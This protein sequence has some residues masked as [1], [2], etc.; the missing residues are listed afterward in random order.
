MRNI[1]N[2]CSFY[3]NTHRAGQQGPS[4]KHS[5][6]MR[7]IYV[8]RGEERLTRANGQWQE[9]ICIKTLNWR[10]CKFHEGGSM[11]FQNELGISFMPIKN[12]DIILHIIQNKKIYL[13]CAWKFSHMNYK[14]QI[15]RVILSVWEC[16]E[17]TQCLIG[18]TAE[19]N[20]S[21]K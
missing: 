15:T 14:A 7:G 8:T 11:R 9:S 10:K 13:S 20:G 21:S 17:M 5:R 3:L 6:E 12:V 19:L 4:T 1:R 18:F 16:L 2:S